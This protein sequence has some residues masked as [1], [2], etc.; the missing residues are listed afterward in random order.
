V[1]RNLTHDCNIGI[2]LASEHAGR[3]TSF[4]TLRNNFVY[5]N[6]SVGIAL[7]GYDTRRGRTENCVIVN[8]TDLT[9]RSSNGDTIR[10]VDRDVIL[11][12]KDLSP[13]EMR[14][15]NAQAKNFDMKARLE[16]AGHEGVEDQF[17]GTLPISAESVTDYIIPVFQT[18]NRFH[19]FHIHCA[20]KVINDN[21][22]FLR[23]NDHQRS[24]DVAH[25]GF[26]PLT[27]GSAE[28]FQG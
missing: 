14:V 10:F 4:I 19:D 6:T 1:E 7:G 27:Q 21:V 9:S 20:V 17:T 5:H 15:L 13:G 23:R 26:G 2:E 12:R 3:S 28:F 18:Q 11:V 24:R 22:T 16:I 8:N 25:D